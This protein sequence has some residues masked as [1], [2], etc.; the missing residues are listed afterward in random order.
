MALY[1]SHEKTS[2]FMCDWRKNAQKLNLI[3]SAEPDQHSCPLPTQH[4]TVKPVLSDH[5]FR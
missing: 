4:Y 5:P 3:E 1:Y 2:S